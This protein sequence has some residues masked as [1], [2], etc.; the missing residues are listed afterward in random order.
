MAERPF[1]IGYVAGAHGIKGDIKVFPATDDITRFER[2]KAVSVE[3]SSGAGD[4]K[5]EKVW[6]HK[7]FVMLKLEGICSMD[8]ALRLKGGEVKINREL[9]LPLSENEYFI[10][11]L[12]DMDVYTED[13]EGLGKIT[14]VLITGANDVYEIEG[15]LYIPAIKDCILNVDVE[16]KKMTVRLLEGLR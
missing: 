8:D 2:L 6:Y 9:A 16:S 4:Y 7:K 14:D 10:R 11:D 15:K 3:T 1:V 13:G 5:I 12:L